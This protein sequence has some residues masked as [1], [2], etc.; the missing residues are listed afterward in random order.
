M[1]VP[2]A[3]TV[4]IPDDSTDATAGAAGAASPPYGIA[5]DHATSKV[6]AIGGWAVTEATGIE[7]GNKITRIHKNIIF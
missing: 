5:F 6:T 1:Q 4:N 7:T 2:T 3:L